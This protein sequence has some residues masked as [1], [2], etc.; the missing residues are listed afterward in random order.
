[1]AMILHGNCQSLRRDC[2]TATAATSLLRD[3][4]G[5]GNRSDEF[6][7]LLS[8]G[9]RSLLLLLLSGSTV[10]AI[11]PVRNK[12]KNF[13]NKKEGKCTL[14]TAIADEYI[15]SFSTQAEKQQDAAIAEIEKDTP[16]HAIRP[17]KLGAATIRQVI[18]NHILA[19]SNQ[20]SAVQQAMEPVLNVYAWADLKLF[21]GTTTNAGHHL[22][23][24]INRTTTVLGEAV[25]ATLL[26]TPTSDL[27]VLQ[28]RQQILQVLLNNP[29]QLAALKKRLHDY[30]DAEQSMV[31]FW[32]TTDPLYTK[33]Y[34]KYM[35]DNFY[36]KGNA[37]AN[38][39]AG[40]LEFKKRLC[41]D[42]WS[43]QLHFLYP[44]TE[45]LIG[46]VFFRKDMLAKPPWREYL[47]KS[48]IPYYGGWYKWNFRTD[49]INKE[50]LAPSNWLS[51]EPI[52]GE[53]LYTYIA[54]T[55]LSNYLEYSAVLRNLALR[56]A[57]VQT[58]VLTAGQVSKTIAAIPELEERYGKHLVAVR[59]LL[60]QAKENTEL[61]RL[62]G[63][64]QK[65][66]FKDWSYFFNNAGKLLAGH[67]LFVEHKNA[68]ADAMYEIGLL[69]AYLSF[70]TLMQE[71]ST[72]NQ[73]HAYVF[74]QFLDRQ[75]KSKPYIKIEDMWNPFLDS[76]QAVGNTL[77]MDAA[78]GGTRTV[79]LT[80]PNAG[81]K[82]TFLTGITHTLLLAHVM[83]IG[84]AGKIVLTPFNKIN[85]YLDITDDIAAGK[86]LFMAEV[87]RAQKH[88]QI[89]K[90][91]QPDEFS[92]TIFDDLFS[93]TNPIEGAAA[94]YSILESLADYTN[95]FTI[96][97]THY[98]LVM[99]LEEKA[100]NKG[101][102]NYKVYI[103]RQGASR[104]LNYTY[105]IVPGRS[106]QAIAIDI[107][108]EQGYDTKMLARAREIIEHP[109]SY[110]AKL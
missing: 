9:S 17:P 101:F 56:M 97:A 85:T 88:I 39:S 16:T 76:K 30:H 37:T 93:G 38:K 52:L 22:L 94:Q 100:G 31:S 103:T 83:G 55:G 2:R 102:A 15:K 6:L 99:L 48:I 54:Y 23:S 25:L 65:L 96:V 36:A 108:E 3:T 33:E 81:G 62:I 84:P 92:F 19:K 91:L 89:L 110:Q 47:W 51:V 29:S 69:D 71:A 32:T 66:P 79:I 45:P 72:Y 104:K 50:G 13:S 109:E 11:D 49:P 73:E 40:W 41:R 53:V 8:S 90:N 1:M 7:Q 78:A 75:Q 95:S 61:G 18:F 42:F 68:F 14:V 63:Y 107:L 20:L 105:K 98:P 4:Q 58:F 64:L 82:S 106:T 46:E 67:K 60:A 70:A 80:G 5:H 28:E 34:V 21:Y 26:V 35:E 43:I 10:F 77:A 24:R 59:A 57:D 87:D 74:A 86:S 44:I 12:E 27:T